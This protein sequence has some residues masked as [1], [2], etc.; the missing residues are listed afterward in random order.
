MV[1]PYG[2]KT[3]IFVSLFEASAIAELANFHWAVV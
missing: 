1:K 3:Q 2:K